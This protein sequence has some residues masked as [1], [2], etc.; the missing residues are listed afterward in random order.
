MDILINVTLCIHANFFT[1]YSYVWELLD[2][3]GGITFLT[4]AKLIVSTLYIHR[5]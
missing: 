2:Y 5:Q 4:T 3:L 1:I